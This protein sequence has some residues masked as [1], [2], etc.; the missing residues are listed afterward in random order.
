MSATGKRRRVRRIKYLQQ[1]AET[2]P[3]EFHHAWGLR[4]ESWAEVAVKR[5]SRLT[6]G[7]GRSARGAWSVTED[8][9]AVLA[10][11]GERAYALEAD[12][13][14]AILDHACTVAVARKW[15]PR[16]HRMTRNYA[17]NR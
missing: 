3:A 17:T 14:R 5:V 1:L 2:N 4:L 12:N 11:C 16:L 6:T 9:L 7:D 10:R 13:T 15:N 8:A